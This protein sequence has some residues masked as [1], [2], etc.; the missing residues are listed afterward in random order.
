MVIYDYYCSIRS[1]IIHWLSYDLLMVMMILN[2]LIDW[3]IH[4]FIDSLIDLFIHSLID[5]I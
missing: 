2:W 1:I 3:L 4:W 5:Y